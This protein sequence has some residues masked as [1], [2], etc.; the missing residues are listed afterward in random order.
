MS[1]KLVMLPIN[2]S[3]GQKEMKEMIEKIKD[4]DNKK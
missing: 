1:N 2:S 4:Y 3:L